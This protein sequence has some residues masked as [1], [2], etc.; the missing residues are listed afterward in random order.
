MHACVSQ[1]VCVGAE[2]HRDGFRDGTNMPISRNKC[3]GSELSNVDVFKVFQT[4]NM[5]CECFY[6]LF[7]KYLKYT[8][9]VIL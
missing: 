4:N 9:T 2:Y 5:L 6:T 8:A 7:S 3:N 1:T